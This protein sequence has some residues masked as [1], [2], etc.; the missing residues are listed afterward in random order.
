MGGVTIPLTV[1]IKNDK[2]FINQYLGDNRSVQLSNAEIRSINSIT[3]EEILKK[4]RSLS[5]SHNDIGIERYFGSYFWMFWGRTTKIPNI[6]CD[7]RFSFFS[8]NYS[9]IK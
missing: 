7:Y 8:R 2:I 3:A 1:S 5:G 4:M 9:R 6:C